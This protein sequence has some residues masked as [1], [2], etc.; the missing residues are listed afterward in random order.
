M[1]TTSSAVGGVVDPPPGREPAAERPAVRQ[2]RR[3]DPRRRP[4]LPC[5]SDQEHAVL[6]ADQRRQ[7]PQR[8]LP[9]RRRR[10][11]RRHRRRPAAALPA[12][13]DPGVQLPDLALQ[14][15]V[16]PQQRRRHE[17]RHQERHQRLPR[18]LLRA[19]PRPVDEREDRDREARRRSTSRTTAATSSAAAS[20]GRSCRTARTSS[21]RSSA[22]TRTRRRRCTTK[23]LFPSQDGIFATPYRETLFT[24]K[25]TANLTPTQYLTVRYGRNQNSQ[26]YGAAPLATPD[27][28]GDSKNKFNSINVNHNMSL[29]RLEA[30]RVR[31]PVRR[32]RQP[33]LGAQ[34]QSPTSRSPTA[35]PPART[36][37]RRR[38]RRRRSTSSATT[39]PGTSP[40]WAASATTSR[41]ASTSS[42]S[43]ASSSPSTPARASPVHAPD[44]RRQR[45]DLDDHAERRRLARQHPG[46]AVR[47]S[48]CRTTGAP[49]TA[50]TVNLGAALR[51]GD[52]AAVR[53]VAESR[54]T[55]WRSSSARPGRFANVVGYENFG[56]DAEGRHR[57]TASRGSAWCGTCAATRGTCVRAGWGIY[58]DFGYTNSNV[59]FAAAD[60]SGSRFGTVFTAT[61]TS[62]LRN[63]DGSFFQRRPAAVQPGV[64]ERSGR[65]AALRPVGRSAARAARDAARRRSAGRTADRRHGGDGRLRP[66]R[67]QEPEHPAAP[68]H[69][70][71]GARRFADI[72]LQPELAA[73]R[74]RRSAAASRSTTG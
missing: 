74:A 44:R 31:L 11:Q 71:N 14:G 22:R 49:A 8:E 35:S 55:C 15:G 29:S 24:G 64:A 62:G 21:P 70:V 66:H 45:A 73:P 20:A 16:R 41:P 43:R 9:D 56:Q 1:D 72:A 63:P 23:G 59:L 5:R 25:A 68:Q 27:N 69:P 26:P 28:W 19:V 67:R 40:A 52:R 51:P 39:S 2:P 34:Q 3:H 50:L 61:N 53:P 65:P 42:T 18:Q 7:R 32:L 48:T 4:R 60:A 33:H 54:T 36:S 37:T 17:H 46:Q 47:A 58:T 13:G 38:A 6:A 57:T 12:R 30:E 10:Q